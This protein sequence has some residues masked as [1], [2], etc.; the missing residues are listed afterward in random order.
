MDY[1][2][3]TASEEIGEDVVGSASTWPAFLL[4]EDPGPWGNAVLRDS[5]LPGEVRQRLAALDVKVLLVRRHDREG[6]ATKGVRVFAAWTRPGEAWLESV[7][8]DR[9]EDLLDHDLSPLPRGRSLGWDRSREPLFAVCT[10]GRHDVCCAERGRPVA[11]A[12]HAAQPAYAWECSHLGGDRFAANV[13]VLPEGLYY[14]R[15]EAEEVAGLAQRHLAGD[16]TLDR[17]RGRCSYAFPVQAAEV[18]LRRDQQVVADD[19]LVLRG[20]RRDGPRTTV[21]FTVRPLAGGIEGD[22]EVL[23][24]RSGQPD[25]IRLT[26]GAAA[27]ERPPLWTVSALERP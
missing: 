19:G 12:L 17:L 14:G 11:A 6:R 18:W 13:L 7:Q 24:V 21:R 22:H 2:C 1:R 10:H 25:A 23:V 4:V 16:L 3:S 15:V 20:V 5:R 27:E 8:L 9:V 26:C